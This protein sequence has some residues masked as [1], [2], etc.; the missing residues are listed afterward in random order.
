MISISEAIVLSDQQLLIEIL[1]KVT[2]RAC[3][4]PLIAADLASG[5]TEYPF[6]TFSII[7][8]DQEITSDWINKHRIYNCYIQ[9]DAHADDFWQACNLSQKLFEALNDPGYRRFFSQC[10]IVPGQLSNSASRS[11]LEGVNYDYDFG[12]DVLFQV[13]A[14]YKFDIGQLNFDY[15]A[16]TSIESVNISD[17]IDNQS[18][19]EVNKGDK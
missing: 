17:L 16:E 4:T 14:G 19:I 5:R 8:A 15:S 6:F 3:N 11:V 7:Q 18:N 12:F 13:R 1:S 9:V 10:D 2:E